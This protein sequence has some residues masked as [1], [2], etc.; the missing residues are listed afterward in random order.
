VKV[1]TFF[2]LLVSCG[3]ASAQ[4]TP[5]PNQTPAK[6]S[7]VSESPLV[8]GG[9]GTDRGKWFE[10]TSSTVP[11]G[12]SIVSVSFR[13][14]GPHPCSAD[15]NYTVGQAEK[16]GDDSF[17]SD[18]MHSV[19]GVVGRTMHLSYPS[20]VGVGS[21]AECEQIKLSK[22]SVTWHFR[23]QG[24]TAED[25]TF[26]IEKNSDTDPSCKQKDK[27]AEKEEYCRQ[28]S[29]HLG[30]TSHNEAIRQKAKLLTIAIQQ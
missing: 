1:I 27:T 22:S 29:V 9:S 5:V 14:E 15:V 11:A 24:W 3:I 2:L 26:A 21:W 30:W 23:F 10:I 8:T 6:L 28:T 7:C 17:Y 25:R 16:E 19:T 4:C 20:K 18:I 12:Y 13:L